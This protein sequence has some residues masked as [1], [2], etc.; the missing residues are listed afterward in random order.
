MIG[1]IATIEDVI[2]ALKNKGLKLK[3]MK[4]LQDYLS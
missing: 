1:N 2:K 4:G 3:I